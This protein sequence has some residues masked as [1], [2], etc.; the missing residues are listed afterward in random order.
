MTSGVAVMASAGAGGETVTTLVSTLASHSI[1]P[2]SIVLSLPP[3][4]A[5]PDDGAFGLSLLTA[6]A[7]D[8]ATLRFT[9]QGGH[10]VAAG[11]LAALACRVLA[12]DEVFG[13]YLVVAEVVG[14]ETGEGEPL[15]GGGPA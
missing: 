2:P 15:L 8:G 13:R 4:A 9:G 3:G 10:P 1:D 6:A 14:A 11:A 12:A 5:L 7:S